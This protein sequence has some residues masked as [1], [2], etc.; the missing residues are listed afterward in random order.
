MSKPVTRTTACSRYSKQRS[1]TPAASSAPGPPNPGASWATTARPV[2]RTDAASVAQSTGE[3]E[4]RSTT[5]MD[6][7]SSRAASA[8]SRATWTRPPKVMSV[9]SAPGTSTRA[10]A[11][12]AP[13]S[14]ASAGGATP[15]PR[16]AG[17][18]QHLALQVVAP[19]RLEEQ[20]RVVA[21]DRLLDETE[22]VLRVRDADDAEARGVREVGLRRVRVVLRRAD[23]S[24]D[25]HSDRDG[26]P[27]APAGAGPHPG[28]L[29]DDLVERRVDDPVELDLADRAVAAVG[30]TDGG[31]EDGGL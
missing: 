12:P 19:L 10:A 13:A 18:R 23:P 11:M 4:R 15:A 27:H 24:P 5:S 6:T 3:S 17:V 25:G 20:H 9:T 29:A 16:R 22:A 28:D 14:P 8:A 26:H 7:P 21:G 30:E 2:L 31:A 1:V